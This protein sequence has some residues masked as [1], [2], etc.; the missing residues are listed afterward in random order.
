MEGK[1]RDGH[2]LST[3]QCENKLHKSEA[4]I[5]ASAFAR[6]DNRRGWDGAVERGGCRVKQ[7]EVDEQEVQE[8]GGEGI[9][10]CQTVA[11]CERA[12]A[13]EVNQFGDCWS[14]V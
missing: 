7:G 10:W 8:G 5:R 12:A 14:G 11:E 4:E 3:A 6:E 13:G 2:I 9:L 1:C